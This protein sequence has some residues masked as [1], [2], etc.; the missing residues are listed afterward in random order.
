MELV[1][2][3]TLVYN[4]GNKLLRLKENEVNEK[5]I[6]ETAKSAHKQ[7][8]I[9]KPKQEEL[10]G[11]TL[12][13]EIKFHEKIKRWRNHDYTWVDLTYNRIAN[14]YS[15][16]IL[17]LESGIYVQSG[18]LLGCWEVEKNK[19]DTLRWH[20]YSEGLHPIFYFNPYRK[21]YVPT[22][23]INKFIEVTLLSSYGKPL[24]WSRS[25]IPFSAIFCLTDHCD[26]DTL[27]LL[28]KQRLLLKK[29]GIK[30][31]KG[32]FIYHFSKRELN[33]AFE[34]PQVAKELKLWKQEG[35]ELFFHSLSQSIKNNKEAWDD[36]YFFEIPDS[37]QPITT[38]VDHGYHP[39]NFTMQKGETLQTKWLTDISIRKGI[40][41]FWNYYDTFEDAGTINQISVE[42]LCTKFIFKTKLP[43]KEKIRLLLYYHTE[44]TQIFTYRKWAGIIKS[45]VQKPTLK[46]IISLARESLKIISII[47]SNLFKWI[48]QSSND[49]LQVKFGPLI[50]KHPSI[51]NIKIFQTLAI[52]NFN[53]AFSESVLSDFVKECGVCIAHT[54]LST[55]ERHH[56]GRLFLNDQ[57]MIKEETYKAWE[58]LGSYIKKGS[59]W[60][61]TLSELIEWMDDFDKITFDLSKD[62]NDFVYTGTKNVQTRRI[63]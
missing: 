30:I 57:G 26:F 23:K 35:H 17:Q 52:K 32:F 7:Q 63:Y 31:S 27:E 58:R 3:I 47:Y 20:F 46:N 9:I 13:I 55:L 24:E 29:F 8:I 40:S 43:I 44:E 50:F 28:K 53:H 61:P 48:F 45:L 34:Q 51:S 25:P 6:F 2:N 11:K 22:F 18:Q 42:K 19:P 56:T 59:I 36:F 49:K 16:K 21:F 14:E 5:I 33:A 60:N 12:V 54:Y 15:P 4:S 10:T 38:W 41:V 1:K 37:I 39:Y 62:C